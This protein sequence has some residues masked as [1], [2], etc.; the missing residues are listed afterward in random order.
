MRAVPSQRMPAHH[1]RSVHRRGFS[2]IELMVA[3]AIG[4]FVVA[5]TFVFIVHQNRLL[6]FTK[7]D[8]A[9]DR[10]GRVALDLLVQDLRH[11]G[12]GVGYR[13][14]GTFNGLMLGNFTVPGGASFSAADRPISLISSERG[15]Q[16]AYQSI[17][18]DIGIRLANGSY[19]SI[20]EYGP[21]FGQVC[22]GGDFDAGDIVI[23]Q[24]ED[25]VDAMTAKIL[26]ISKAPSCSGGT[27]AQGC[28][29]FTWAPDPT[30]SVG[31][32]AA[33]AE[34]VGGEMA[35]GFREIVW[36]VGDDG[37]LQRAEVT[38]DA[39]CTA[40]DDTCGGVVAL[41]VETLQ[42]RIWQWDAVAG[43]WED[44]TPSQTLT[45][46]RRIR[47]DVELVIR[48]QGSRDSTQPPVNLQ[49]APGNCLPDCGDRDTVARRALR[50]SV[51]V[52]NSGRLRLM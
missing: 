8:L 50:T 19:R 5:A 20:T 29:V 35:G 32:N 33:T 27:C 24:T 40:R 41:D 22:A 16:R 25:G 1:H 17:T 15:V 30:F 36:F 47:V 37:R 12:V 44:R 45:D 28:D 2:L 23:F 46:D 43:A 49:L 51:E 26:G 39:P 7:R 31:P 21:G 34:Y 3:V 48:A 9:R 6:E 38:A 10:S 11:A 13:A 18:D 42:M 52:R 4:L 14:D